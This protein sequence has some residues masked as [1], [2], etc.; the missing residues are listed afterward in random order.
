MMMCVCFFGVKN[1]AP[2]NFYVIKRRFCVRE[3]NIF[4][5]ET[6]NRFV[7]GLLKF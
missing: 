2:T 3:L 4:R 7:R 1:E 6:F 5:Y